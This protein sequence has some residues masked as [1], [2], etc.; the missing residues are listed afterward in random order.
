MATLDAIG[1]RNWAAIGTPGKYRLPNHQDD[2]WIYN[3]RQQR[4][5]NKQPKCWQEYV[6]H[7]SKSGC[8][9]G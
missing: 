9:Q 1:M 4:S 2:T 5:A 3:A 7:N 8:K 6:I